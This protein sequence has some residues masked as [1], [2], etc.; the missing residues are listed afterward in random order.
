[1]HALY[2]VSPKHLMKSIKA[3][4]NYPLTLRFLHAFVLVIQLLVDHVGAGR[5]DDRLPEGDDGLGDGRLDPGREG[6]LEVVEAALE[7][8]LACRHQNV[9]AL[10]RQFDL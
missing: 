2:V 3:I 10:V 6:I 5:H 7:V 4:T 8:H 1:M 9:L